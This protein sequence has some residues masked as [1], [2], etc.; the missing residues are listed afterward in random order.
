MTDNPVENEKN[1]TSAL[2]SAL[3]TLQG[4]L[5]REGVEG[6][7][8][9]LAEIFSY[10]G[11]LRPVVDDAMIAVDT[12]MGAGVSL[13]D[14]EADH[15][16]EWV[17]R[18]DDISWTYSNAYESHLKKQKWSPTVVQSLSD[19]SLRIL[20]H[21]QDP[22]SEGAWNR[23]GLVIGHVQSGKTASYMGVIAKAAD[24]GYKFIIVIAGIHNNLRKQTQER[25]DEAFIGRS[26]DP[27][28]QVLVG[29]GLDRD[30]PHP[31]TLTNIN[32]DFNR[33]TAQKSMMKINDF[34]KPFILV[35]KKNVST[36]EALHQ[37]LQAFNAQKNGQI[38]DV[39][40]LL[41]D[42]EADN[43]S[44]NTNK[45]ELKPTRTN[46][47]IRK[48]L[49]LFTKSCY[50]GYTATPF[51]NIFINPAAYD[52]EAREELFP[53]DFI[54]CLDAPTTYFG[55][56]KVFLEEESSKQILQR[57]SDCENYIPL[58]HKKDDPITAL[59]PSLYRAL[60]QFIIVRAIR[61]LRGQS[62][63]HCSMMVNVSRFVAVQ[64]TVRDLISLH[65]KKLREAV[66]A[67]YAM[68][69]SV[70]S[71]N[72][73]MQAL[74]K[75]FGEDYSLC[76]FSWN[77][78]KGAL[79][80]VFENL[81]IFVVNSKSDE[82]LDYRKYEKDGRSLT[83]VA[84]GGLSLSRGLTIEGLCVSYMYR[85]TR[86]YDT[87]MQMGRWFGY[88]S[89][90]EDLCRVHLG[91]DSIDWYGHIADASEELRQQIIRMRK[92]KLSPRQFGLY[93]KAHPD[94]L[95]IT[96]ANKMRSGERVIMK[97]NFSGRLVES[98]VVPEDSTVNSHNERLITDFWRNGFGGAAL[99]PTGK[100]WIAEDVSLEVIEEFL[101]K[102]RVHSSFDSQKNNV[103]SY[104]R[105]IF[106][107]YNKGDVLLISIKGN[108]EDVPEFLLGTQDRKSATMLPGEDGWRLSKDRVASRGDEK[109]GLTDTQQ[110][111]ATALASSK[112]KKPSD[113]HYRDVRKKP[114]L[115]IHVLGPIG[116]EGKPD[117]RIPAFGISFPPGLYSTEIDVVANSVWI[118]QMS[119]SVPDDPDDEEDYDE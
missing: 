114:L 15:D 93:V 3:A 63:K 37:W 78:V 32:E 89:G 90:F 107:V 102:F 6:K 38:T 76:G 92:D 101:V 65:E 28:N 29:V 86:M 41:I 72:E 34:S 109:L 49:G 31:A 58:T 103:I 33:H 75:V 59:P 115:M 20:G 16:D 55:P 105:E 35:I 23:R 100:G 10:E 39:P 62:S 5:T 112:N 77:A 61:N 21:L 45:P 46:S 119:E 22:A 12:R 70:S 44:I 11:D 60:H 88:R 52:D 96:A 83:A 64:K 47:M 73:Y 82:V 99:I 91:S 81:R 111:E 25:I 50:L 85:N 17:F 97:Q 42:D 95:L 26:S 98:Y 66:K 117:I 69:E 54:Y 1:L 27:N 57:I 116:E 87:L 56:D 2:I 51:A 43:A 80:G 94:S 53:K 24:A 36:L 4:P 110:K 106:S 18:R 71:C 9:A 8:R 68:H 108:G 19:V 104:L 30:Y 79:W 113:V 118:A 14:P 84:I 13:V 67:N 48:I 7:A 40:M 74:K